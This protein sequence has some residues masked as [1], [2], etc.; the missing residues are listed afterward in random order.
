LIKQILRRDI[1]G[2]SP[3]YQEILEEGK[4][5]GRLEGRLEGSQERVR[6]IARNLFSIGMTPEQV[7]IATGLTIS[8]LPI[9]THCRSA[10]ELWDYAPSSLPSQPWDLRIA[11]A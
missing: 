8:A 10:D 5:A 1:M 4:Q 11:N 9:A 7:A 6:M 2:E 3:I